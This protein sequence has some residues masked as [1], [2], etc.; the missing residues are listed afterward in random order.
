MK[1]TGKSFYGL[2]IIGVLS[3]DILAGCGTT[4]PTTNNDENTTTTPPSA[5]VVNN[6]GD[7][8][9][10]VNV[11][12]T[13]FTLTGY[14]SSGG[15][16]GFSDV[17]EGTNTITLKQTSTSTSVSVN[18]LNSLQKNNSYAVNISKVSGSYC[19]EL[20]QMLDTSTPF[21]DNTTRVLIGTT[22]TGTAPATPTSVTATAGDGQVTISWSAVSDATSYNVYWSA[23]TGVTKTSGTKITG[24]TSPY[25]H[26]TLTNDTTYYYV[27]TA[28]N[29]SG[30]SV[31]STEVLAT[32]PPSPS[33][34]LGIFPDESFVNLPPSMRDP[35]DGTKILIV[36]RILLPSNDPQSF[37]IANVGPQGS[38][39]NYL[40]TNEDFVNGFVYQNGTGSLP[41]GNTAT[42]TVSV[43]PDFVINSVT[44]GP[45]LL[46]GSTQVL[47]IVTPDAANITKG[48][49]SLEIRS[50][51]VFNGTYTGSFSVTCPTCFG[52]TTTAGTFTSTLVN[53]E[54]TNFSTSPPPS[55][56]LTQR[57]CRCLRLE[58]SREPTSRSS[59]VIV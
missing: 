46:I 59:V 13:I 29:S 10:Q 35:F 25:T 20:W 16:T 31:E 8:I 43:H 4:I 7:S 19:A 1:R 24:V 26:A 38:I 18:S 51:N 47:S 55:S 11:G 30:E 34:V 22:C 52:G 39:L 27:V 28:V 32:T 48:L 12:D 54:F 37:A 21:N 36:K 2:L 9:Y 14:G 57:R 49:L 45:S 53:G 17:A 56:P 15:S 50:D 6:S 40:V 5:Q 42:V 44:G 58:P 41:A 23:T 33:P 3:L